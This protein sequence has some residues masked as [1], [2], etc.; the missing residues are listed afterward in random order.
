MRC[1]YLYWLIIPVII[2]RIKELVKDKD[3]KQIWLIDKLCTSNNMI[4]GYVQN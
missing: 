4:N 2:N 1:F 3:I